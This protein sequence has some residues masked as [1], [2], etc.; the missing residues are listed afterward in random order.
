MKQHDENAFMYV[1]VTLFAIGFVAL[2]AGAQ[3]VGVSICGASLICLLIGLAVA[4]RDYRKRY[5][6]SAR[7]RRPPD[8]DDL[9][10]DLFLL[11]AAL[12]EDGDGLPD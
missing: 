9:D 2:Q 10:D 11:W 6:L 5:P 12:D 1:A 8:D 3:T 7:R 4:E